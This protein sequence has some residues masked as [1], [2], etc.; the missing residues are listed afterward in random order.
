MADTT[1]VDPS[2]ESAA[3]APDPVNSEDKPKEDAD[4]EQSPPPPA[5]PSVDKTTGDEGAVFNDTPVES[6]K[7]TNENNSNNAYI[8]QQRGWHLKLSPSNNLSHVFY[9]LLGGHKLSLITL[10]VIHYTV[11]YATKVQLNSKF[12]GDMMAVCGLSVSVPADCVLVFQHIFR[13]WVTKRE[14]IGM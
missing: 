9:K 4:A 3:P 10:C 11:S 8:S 13:S 12:T 5:E 7:E 2:T 1:A 14:L 6:L